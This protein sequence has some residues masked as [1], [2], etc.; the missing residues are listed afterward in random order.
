MYGED[1]FEFSIIEECSILMLDEREIFWIDKFRTYIGFD[2]C[3]GYNKDLGCKGIRGYKHT[4]EEIDKMRRI[5]NPD[6]VLQFD[7][8]FNFVKEWIGGASHIKRELGYTKECIL[9]RCNHTILNKMT[10]YKNYYWIY[11]SEFESES[12]SWNNYLSQVR[13]KNERVICQYNKNFELLRKWNSHFELK[14]EGYNIK[15]ILNICNHWGTQKTYC[16]CIWAYDDYD[17]SD[18]YF[19]FCDQYKKG[20]HNCRKVN[21]KSEKDGDIINSFNSITEA[22]I[23][24]GKPNKFR[25]NIIK[26]ISKNHKS[27]G[28][29]WEYAD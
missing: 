1:N 14:D 25:N 3:Q 2:D 4:Q 9:L 6:I 7:L 10:P 26:A 12:F 27:A 21:M 28:Y 29:Y 18:G 13:H 24:L 17:F 20:Q 15:P 16:D 5:Q 19:G 11:K 23:F 22:C 8:D